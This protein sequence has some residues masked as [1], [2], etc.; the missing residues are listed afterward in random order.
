MTI[1]FDVWSKKPGT[2]HSDATMTSDQANGQTIVP[3]TLTVTP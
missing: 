3:Q 1:P 2:F